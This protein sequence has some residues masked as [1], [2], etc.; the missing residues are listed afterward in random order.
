MNLKKFTVE[1]TV[2][3]KNIHFP[4]I[5]FKTA[6]YE[7]DGIVLDAKMDDYLTFEIK[8]KDGS[9]FILDGV[10]YHFEQV[11]LNYGR[12]IV[13]DSGRFFMEEFLP[14]QVWSKKYASSG[15]AMSNPFF[16]LNNAHDEV[17]FAF[18]LLGNIYETEIHFYSPGANKKNSMTVHGGI[19]KGKI[20]W[21][22]TKPMGEGVRIG[23][24]KSF[25]D[26]IFQTTGEKSWFHALRKYGAVFNKLQKTKYVIQ[27]EGFRPALCTWRV[28]NSDNMT[29]DWIIKTAKL[30]KEVGMKALI[31]D[32]GWYGVGLDGQSLRSTMGDWPSKIEG[33]FKDIRKTIA[34]VKKI[35]I[36]PVLWYCPIS[37]SPDAKIKP[38]VKHLL[39]HEH[40][41]L[42]T[43]PARFHT[44][45]VRSPE[46]R[47]V[48]VDNLLKLIDYG[49]AGLKVDLFD[50]MPDTPCTSTEHKH[51]C[52]TTT[53]GLRKV[54]KELYQ[55]TLKRNKK[56][57]YSIKNNYGNVELA[58]YGSNVRGGDSPFDENINTLRSIYPSAYVPV[59]HDDYLAFTNFE[60]PDKVAILLMK[61]ITTGVPN[62]SLNL[63]KL[64]KAHKVILTNWLNFFD[65]NLDL[66][67][68]G[69]LKTFE[70]QNSEMNVFQR[71]IPTKA[72][73]SLFPNSREFTF[74]D[75]D[76]VIVLNTT[77]YND[78]Y[79]TD[80]PKGTWIKEDY[81][82]KVEVTK[83]T[84]DFEFKD[85]IVHIPA[86]G[87]AI[88]KKAK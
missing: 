62:F 66:Y 48:M 61:Q 77:K 82:Y 26:G 85:R 65:S 17:D 69:N 78:V 27:E 45:C 12:V 55:A 11:L 24:V 44:L 64:G 41:E 38:K 56:L 88:F 43:C 68:P 79:L 86:A 73:I 80:V 63:E 23:K 30:A 74:L 52:E 60:K 39:S 4:P 13:P 8:K 14:R 51:D 21:K 49:A 20:K 15:R 2:D 87:M 19:A 35:G 25:K 59:V 1:A 53:D 36:A 34:E 6:K 7:K 47:K 46:A 32:D 29:H 72:M 10:V 28:I 5:L 71:V 81:N 67:K 76:T 31:F 83:T 40:G 57:I 37:V 33:K 9:S 84:K 3:G 18:G 50:Y 70:P 58:V 22:I 16:V 42:Y 75:K 54:Y